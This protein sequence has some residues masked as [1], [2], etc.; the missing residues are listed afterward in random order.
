VFQNKETDDIGIGQSKSKQLEHMGI[1]GQISIICIA[2][3]EES[4]RKASLE[5]LAIQ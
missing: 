2:H 5:D 3:V 1:L 4:E